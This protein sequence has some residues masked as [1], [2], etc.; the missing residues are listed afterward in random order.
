MS[1]QVRRARACVVQ[2]DMK[3]SLKGRARASCVWRKKRRQQFASNLHAESG[4]SFYVRK[5]ACTEIYIPVRAAYDA[6]LFPHEVDLEVDE[7]RIVVVGVGG[8][9]HSGGAGAGRLEV[10]AVDEA[11]RADADRPAL[12]LAWEAPDSS[13]FTGLWL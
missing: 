13:I 7:T 4:E 6:A 5:R 12:A 2:V 8:G 10:P 3:A 11:R 9:V 1:N